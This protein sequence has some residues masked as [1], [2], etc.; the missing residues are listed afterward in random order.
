MHSKKIRILTSDQ[1]G[2]SFP[3]NFSAWC[4]G[5]LTAMGCHVQVIKLERLIP[6]Y[7]TSK[8]E[9][10]K[11]LEA[12]FLHSGLLVCILP[13]YKN[14]FPS[15]LESMLTQILPKETSMI[16]QLIAIAIEPYV[17]LTQ[18]PLFL[19]RFRY[20]QDKFMEHF[21]PNYRINP[22][23]IE[24]SMDGSMCPLFKEAGTQLHAIIYQILHIQ[25][26]YQLT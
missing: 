8:V 2:S 14:M 6:S 20:P 18:I 25:Q 19:E 1:F 22:I 17:R 21:N 4:A 10:E 16:C 3:E 5:A 24:H 11:L 9:K 23:K 12:S 13:T 15:D 26:K 7:F